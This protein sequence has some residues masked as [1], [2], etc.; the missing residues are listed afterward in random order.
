M[1]LILGGV[2]MYRNFFGLTS[3]PFKIT[4]DI[5]VFY[6]DGSREDILAALVYTV[7]R[8]DGI[9]KVSGEV[10]CGKTMLLR[11]LENSLTNE[12]SIVYINSPN[13]SAKDMLLY[14]CAELSLSVD[15]DMMKFTLLN[16]LTNELLRLHSQGRK[17]VMLIDEAQAMTFDTL[18]EIRLLSNIETAEDKLLQIVLF[19]QPELDLALDNEKIRQLKNR[20]S[21]SIYI[22]PLNPTEVNSYLNYRMRKSSYD[23]LDIFNNK[24][25]EQ[26][27]KLSGGLPR[28]INTIADKLLMSAY[29][30]GDKTISMKH[31]KMLPDIDANRISTTRSFT[32]NY[33]L[34]LVIFVL[35]SLAIYFYVESRNVIS[36]NGSEFIGDIDNKDLISKSNTVAK[37]SKINGLNP[38]NKV[39]SHLK[40]NVSDYYNIEN[41]LTILND[42]ILLNQVL[43]YHISAKKWI[44]HMA[45]DIYVIQ[46]ASPGLFQLEKTL[47]YYS[48]NQISI[49]SL[50]ILIDSSK[51]DGRFRLKVFYT[52][53][54]GYLSLVEIIK[55][56]PS[57][58]KKAQPYITTS[59]QLVKNL[60]Y[61]DLQL[62]LHGIINVNY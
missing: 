57:G 42:P 24:V 45:D 29:S 38:S 49:D 4:P 9:V 48:D 23:G 13:L 54:N 20:I 3:L 62:K 22:P 56:L 44:S 55:N 21:Y 30:S 36:K 50:H 53:S 52:T 34:I 61:T 7:S 6:T 17:V 40:L 51:V 39:T 32:L 47:K 25:S 31:I 33:I 43:T 60:E 12:F 11:L 35:A 59:K 28:S 58:L 27:H 16:T 2:Y 15:S 5:S 46:L 10:G 1:V 8:G 41:P 18:E 19:G 37:L 14:I 26:V